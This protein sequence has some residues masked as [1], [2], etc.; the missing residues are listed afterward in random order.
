VRTTGQYEAARGG[1]TVYVAPYQIP[2]LR[3][4]LPFIKEQRRA[5]GGDVIGFCFQ[6]GAHKRIV[7]PESGGGNPLRRLGLACGFG[8]RNVY[9]WNLCERSCELLV[10]QPWDVSGCHLHP[11]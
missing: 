2:R 3:H 6:A 9:C 10:E 11:L 5:Q 8:A 4:S 1:V 7:K